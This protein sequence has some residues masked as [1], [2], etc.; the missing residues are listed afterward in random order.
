[1][2]DEDIGRLIR[3]MPRP[4]ASSDFS[5]RV[6]A[7]LG[8]AEKRGRTRRRSLVAALAASALLLGLF[9]QGYVM[10]RIERS[11]AAERVQAM[12]DEYRELQAELEKLRALARD[13]DPILDLG[14]TE[15]VDFVFDLRELA[16]EAE[17]RR[18]QD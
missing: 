5:G 1:M 13:A 12:R 10:R 9:S 6:L 14:G 11:R 16:N 2:S 4:A 17:G 15:S 18:R 8:E 7:K 3:E